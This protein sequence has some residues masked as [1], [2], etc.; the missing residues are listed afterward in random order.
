MKRIVMVVPIVI[1]IFIGVWVVQD[2][3]VE[4]DIMLLGFPVGKL[5]LGLW[6]LVFFLGGLIA[7]LCLSYPTI[8][9]LK[10]QA[11]RKNKILKTYE[12]NLVKA[13]ENSTAQ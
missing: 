6:M 1:A 8:F 10:R 5:P 13:R 2:N 7:G 11:K 9:G 3:P 4:T 12:N